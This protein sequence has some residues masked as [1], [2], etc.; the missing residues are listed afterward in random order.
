MLTFK[1]KTVE[2][3]WNETQMGYFDSSSD[4][5]EQLLFIYLLDDNVSQF[6]YPLVNTFH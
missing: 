4:T 2:T 1:S 3:Y 6:L 5:G